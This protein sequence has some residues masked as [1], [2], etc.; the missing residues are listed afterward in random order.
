MN[1]QEN[2]RPAPPLPRACRDSRTSER[3]KR[4]SIDP[5]PEMPGTGANPPFPDPTKRLE[6]AAF[7][8]LMVGY[9]L[10]ATFH[11]LAHPTRRALLARLGEGDKC[12]AELTRGLAI[13]GTAA[14]K[15]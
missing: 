11:A 10:D 15:H 2:F 12:V 6:V 7:A 5:A 8:N 3:V 14:A 4:E 9:R 13:S 1:E